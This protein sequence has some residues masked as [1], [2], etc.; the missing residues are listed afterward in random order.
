[1]PGSPVDRP[2][3][4][5]VKELDRLLTEA[6]DTT[7]EQESLNRT[8]WQV[9]NTVA[10]AGRVPREELAAALASFADEASVASV[11]AR[12]AERGWVTDADP[13]EMTG[14][15]RAA[16]TDLLAAVTRVRRAAVDGVEDEDYQTT[17]STLARMVDNLSQS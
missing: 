10:T 11:V 4:W 5:W 1:M 16:H 13:V 17:V 12:L 6:L 9:L 14:L 2:I 3:G 15:G 8:G 7:L